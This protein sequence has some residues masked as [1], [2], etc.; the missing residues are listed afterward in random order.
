MSSEEMII[1]AYLPNQN[2][3][4]SPSPSITLKP[5]NQLLKKISEQNKISNE[6]IIDA[7]F[8]SNNTALTD[9]NINNDNNPAEL[10]SMC[11]FIN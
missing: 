7:S 2:K 1:P 6:I 4:N 5:P 9:L 3:D 8:N 10:D 11:K